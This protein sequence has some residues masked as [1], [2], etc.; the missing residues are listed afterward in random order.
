[1]SPKSPDKPQSR[2]VRV[3]G[4]DEMPPKGRRNRLRK[5]KKGAKS[6]DVMTFDANKSMFTGWKEPETLPIRRPAK[7]AVGATETPMPLRIERLLART[8]L[9]CNDLAKYMGI[10]RTTV[11]KVR[12]GTHPATR[13]FTAKFNM[14]EQRIAAASAGDGILTR[15]GEALLALAVATPTPLE[16]ILVASDAIQLRLMPTEAKN[17]PAVVEV[18]MVRPGKGEGIAAV[19]MALTQNKNDELLLTCFDKEHASLDFISKISPNNYLW[20]LK[21]CVQLILG[22]AW[23]EEL[24]ELVH[25]IEHRRS[26]W[27]HATVSR[28]FATERTASPG[29]LFERTEPTAPEANRQPVSPSKTPPGSV[30]SDQA[31]SERI[32]GPPSD[33]TFPTSELPEPLT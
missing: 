3:V 17:Q 23:K 9:N 21:K 2:L 30:M 16:D 26:K 10:T 27:I 1:M 7:T 15:K 28:S 8:G 6:E 25:N 5:G 32:F 19:T 31:L 20:A 12:K 29:P 33:E 4:S 14:A 18:K 11:H 13:K 22:P 24:Q